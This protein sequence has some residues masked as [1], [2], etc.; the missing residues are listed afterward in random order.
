MTDRNNEDA[1]SDDFY[2]SSSNQKCR[3][4]QWLKNLAID[5][6]QFCNARDDRNQFS[7]FIS[8]NIRENVAGMNEDYS[9]Y[10][11]MNIDLIDLDQ[12]F[13]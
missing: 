8:G 6:G 13:L 12:E 3:A 10:K 11:T 1:E 7:L 9:G 5:D 2:F 4:S